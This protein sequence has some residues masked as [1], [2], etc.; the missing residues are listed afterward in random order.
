V[1]FG[2]Y[3]Q[4]PQWLARSHILRVTGPGGGAAARSANTPAPTKKAPSVAVTSFT[5]QGANYTV[6]SS[7][8]T[9]A[10]ATSGPCWVQV[11]SAASATPLLS[12]VQSAGKRATF[13]ATGTIKV[14]VGSSAV[15]VFVYINGKGAFLNQPHVVPYTYAFTPTSKS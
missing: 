8:F 5:S 10:V 4:R 3:Q 15:A 2:I 6:D 1:G 11:T 12:G 9:V 7:K 14:E 13:V